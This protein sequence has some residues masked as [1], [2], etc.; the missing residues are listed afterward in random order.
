MS[1]PLFIIPAR[2]GSKG[3]PRKNLRTVGGI[4]LVGRAVRACRAACRRL[5]GGRVVVDSDDPE[6]LAEGRAWGAETPYVRPAHLAT[7]TAGSME[8]L[9]HALQAL[10][11]GAED[12][13]PVVLVQATCP[14]TP[15]EHLA[16]AVLSWLHGDGAPVVSVAECDHHPA[17]SYSIDGSG[18]L[19]AVVPAPSGARRQDLPAAWRVTGAAYVGSAGD[20]LAGRHFVEPGRTR[21]VVLDAGLAVDVDREADLVAADALARGRVRAVEVAGR[22]IGPGHP[23]FIVA[24][25]GVN[26]D[27]DRDEAHR[28]IDAAA[29]AGADAV[30]FQTWKTE[31]LCRPGAPKAEYQQEH[32]GAEDDQY[33]M[34]KRLELPFEVH[35]ELKGH[36]EARGLV[37]LSTPD[38]PVSARFLAG[39]GLAALKVSSGEL[40][41]LPFLQLLGSL[42]RPVLLSTGMGTLPEVGAAL[43]ALAEGGDPPVVLFHAVSAYPAPADQMNV[44]AV[45]TLRAAFGVP[46]GLSDHCPGPEAVLATV[47]IGLDIWEKHLT[48]DRTRHG[49]DHAASLDPEQF[50][51]QVE[52]VR[53]AER[54]LGDGRKVAQPA[55][56]PTLAVVRRRLHAASDLPAGHRL[57]ADDVIGLRG[58][59]GVPVSEGRRVLGRR[60]LS[61]RARL[62]PIREQDV[63]E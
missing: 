28:L 19:A 58:S 1:G 39:L 30:K 31:L 57:R 17:W 35:P 10:G 38:D 2:G 4:T 54:A 7:D 46:V 8:V 29:D 24:E 18:R 36:A 50:R 33:A 56:V 13:V 53:S 61:A 60:L 22:L 37:F 15:P 21:V 26:H 47:G 40:D 48:R 5:G 51:R 9:A 16:D 12:P 63:T 45:A 6:V 34:L 42:G 44:R 52:L 14:L 62:D 11:V 55:E 43:D 23:C 59:E 27:G 20:I 32:D 25:A 3:V 41:N 49:P